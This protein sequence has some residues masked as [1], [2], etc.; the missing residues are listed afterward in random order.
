MASVAGLT[1][2]F[3]AANG[4]QAQQREKIPVTDLQTVTTLYHTK[5][6]K[7][8]ADLENRLN[9]ERPANMPRIVYIDPDIMAP[10]LQLKGSIQLYPSMTA[11]YLNAKKVPPLDDA[12][13]VG[14]ATASFNMHP[15]AAVPQL[16][17]PG[18][19]GAEL[20]KST[21]IV[22]PYNP[23]LSADAYMRQAFD[24]ANPKTGEKESI[25]TGLKLQISISRQDMAEIVDAREAWG[26]F[27]TKFVTQINQTR[28][29]D[30]I[31]ALHQT[32]VFKDVGGLMQ[33]VKDG[34]D[35]SLIDKF[36]D[37][38][39]TASGLT[40]RPRGELFSPTDVPFY[41]SVIFQTAPALHEL[42]A[43]ID[44]MGVGKFRSL[45]GEDMIKMAGEITGKSSMTAEQATHVMGFAMLG[46]G[47]F[48]S[49]EMVKADPAAIKSAKEAVVAALKVQND[50]IEKSIRPMTRE[51]IAGSLVPLVT[52]EM[53]YDYLQREIFG[54]PDVQKNPDDPV[55]RFR[56]HQELVDKTRA[57]MDQ[58]PEAEGVI[59]QVLQHIFISNPMMEKAPPPQAP[60]KNL[61]MLKA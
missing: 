60:S 25:M 5:D 53:S 28:D 37:F 7:A 50:A 57:L 49:L 11:E 10:W 34:A 23:N 29:F 18:L 59:R 1:F 17:N 38:R 43:R 13:L 2:A 45:S 24:L 20:G 3:G 51:E 41:G 32:E 47:Y 52:P 33:A 30:R 54:N 46:N 26:C 8:L 58:H 27:D 55:A 15:G 12:T 31:M 36:A 40:M 19:T 16:R 48:R 42:K 9:Q 56:V 4:V 39:A 61:P 35:P 44:Q 14:V 6:S 22:I 21:C